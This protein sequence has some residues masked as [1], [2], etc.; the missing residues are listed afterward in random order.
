MNN[1]LKRLKKILYRSI[2]NN[3]ISYEELIKMSKEKLVYIIDVRSSQE[4]EEGH[5]DGAI[6]ISVYNIENE[7]EKIIKNKEDIIIVYCSSG[8]RSKNAKNILEK[9]GYTNVYNLKNGIDKLW[10]S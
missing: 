1:M 10:V 6:N 8:T 9:L 4:F 7:V 3:E 5:L 2:N